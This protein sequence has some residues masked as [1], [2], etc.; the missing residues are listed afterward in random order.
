MESEEKKEVPL[1]K[2]TAT[3]AS[4]PSP[5]LTVVPNWKKIFWTWSFAF[6]SLS[7][8]LTFVDQLLPFLNILQPV[9]SDNQYAVAMFVLNGLGL[10]SRFIKQK[11]LWEYHPDQEK[12]DDDKLV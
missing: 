8:V 12:Q 6:H 5:K 4:L 11:S 2:D 3:E 9:L 10:L 7:V 1:T